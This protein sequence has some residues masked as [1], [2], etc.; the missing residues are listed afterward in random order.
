MPR[1][2]LIIGGVAGGAS[3]AAR[4]RRLDET[5]E[6]I[7]F[8]R[9]PHVSFANCGL[10]YYV[11]D[12]IS[13]ERKLLVV[14]REM[15]RDRFNI[16]IRIEHEALR[17]DRAAKTVR[18]RN[19]RSGDERDEAYD[20]RCQR[21]GPGAIRSREAGSSRDFDPGAR[22]RFVTWKVLQPRGGHRRQSLERRA[23]ELGC[24]PCVAKVGRHADDRDIPRGRGRG[25]RLQDDDW[26][27]AAENPG[28]DRVVPAA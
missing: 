19:V 27:P 11:G 8:E 4:L 23:P 9:G 2:V 22:G 25:F 6:I 20:V 7:L 12:I 15:F 13:D 1:R 5:P 14:S 24:G 26:Q 18:V 16:D 21:G 28:R 3:T 10:P 17:I